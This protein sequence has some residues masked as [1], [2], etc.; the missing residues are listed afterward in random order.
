MKSDQ[1][2]R[3]RVSL[4]K[5]IRKPDKKSRK[6]KVIAKVK[7]IPELGSLNAAESRVRLAEMNGRQAET[8]LQRM[9][10]LYKGKLVSSEEY[11]K[12]F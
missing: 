6:E 10:K 8:D 11:E 12:L 5:S 7:V 3:S 2:L 4:P 1:N 9:E